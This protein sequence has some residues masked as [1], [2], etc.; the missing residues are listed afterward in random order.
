MKKPQKG[1][2][3]LSPC[4][5]PKMHSFEHQNLFSRKQQCPP[6]SREWR[7]TLI[8][9][10]LSTAKS[11]SSKYY[12]PHVCKI[13]NKSDFFLEI[14]LLPPFSPSFPTA[15]CSRPKPLRSS[16]VSAPDCQKHHLLSIFWA[17]PQGVYS[18]TVKTH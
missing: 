18:A 17:L 2:E 4:P 16:W 11:C 7:L 14:I 3:S 6:A 1:W 5:S 8:S 9:P 10:S 12:E 13:K 15:F